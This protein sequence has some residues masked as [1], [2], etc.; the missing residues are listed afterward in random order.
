MRNRDV[1]K[2]VKKIISE[3]SATD[4]SLLTATYLISLQIAKCKN[5]YSIGEELIKPSLI[6]ACN[7]VLGQPAAH[8]M[9]EIPLSNDAVQRRISDMTEDTET[10][11]IERNYKIEII[12][13]TTGRIFRYSE[14]QHFAYVCTIY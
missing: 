14:Q 13:I 4:T 7:E 1:L 8:K 6:A 5:T 2:I 12:C 10:H 11:L 9:K 3:A